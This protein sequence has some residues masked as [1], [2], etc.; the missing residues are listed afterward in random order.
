MCPPRV[1]MCHG[2]VGGKF[3]FQALP[4]GKP[5]KMYIYKKRPCIVWFLA[6]SIYILLFNVGIQTF[7]ADFLFVKAE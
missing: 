2:C 6:E 4:N 7:K 3:N 1:Q 5:A